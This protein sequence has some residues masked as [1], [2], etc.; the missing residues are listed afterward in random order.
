MAQNIIG[1]VIQKRYRV[2][3]F[4]ASGAMKTVYRVRDLER[5]VPLALKMLHGDLEE[6]P[7]MLRSFKRET[8]AIQE[9]GH[10]NIVRFYGLEQAKKMVFM[11]EEYIDGPAL[12]DILKERKKLSVEESLVYLK[13]MC[14]ALGYAHNRGIVH[15]DVKPGNVMVNQGGEIKLTDFGIARHTG[16]DTTS[17]LAGAGTP[18]Y[19]APE[20]V[21]EKEVTAATDVYALG[22]ML[23]EML[24]GQR[25]FRGT[26]S[27]SE[28]GGNTQN[29]RIRYAHLK[30]DPPDP[31]RLNKALSEELAGAVLKALEKEPRER[32]QTTAE[33][34]ET[35]CQVA[36]I[37][38]ARVSD[39]A[40]LKHTISCEDEEQEEDDRTP[41][42]DGGGFE[43]EFI[44]AWRRIWGRI[45]PQ[46]SPYLAL[47]VVVM[48]MVS[49]FIFR[50]DPGEEKSTTIAQNQPSRSII[51]PTTSP[52]TSDAET[53]TV[54]SPSP[55]RTQQVFTATSVPPTA[56]V[57]AP[58]AISDVKL[59]DAGIFWMGA[60]DEDIRIVTDLGSDFF[61]LFQNELPYHEVYLDAFYIDTYE[62][63]NRK[64]QEFISSTN[65]VTLAERDRSLPRIYLYTPSG[66]DPDFTIDGTANWKNPDARGTGIQKILD[67]PVVFIAWQDANAYCH[68][69]APNGHLPTEAQWVKAAR[70]T[71]GR[72]YP[73]GNIY[74]G[75]FLNGS[76]YTLQ[77]DRSLFM[78]D[79]GFKFTAP[80]GSY[81]QGASPYGVQDMLGNV[82]EWVQ[83]YYDG[84]YYASSPTN[85][86]TGPSI[87]SGDQYFIHGG[88]WYSGPKFN[89][90][91]R[92]QFPEDMGIQQNFG[93][94]CA[95]G[96]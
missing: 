84:N 86:P 17:T 65:Y 8:K 56:T 73:W 88:S 69:V 93:F 62:V 50:P 9:L 19:M 46:N 96:P 48:G 2:E 51:L 79:D 4:I 18:A 74:N 64:F 80:V 37:P 36:G 72:V 87:G 27:G 78:Y 16:S 44:P 76:D 25:P 81:P 11:L 7:A 82:S 58:P 31:R 91:S 34:F 5:S 43:P 40:P 20:Q 10:P 12:K 55:T 21:M 26:E 52:A 57:L 6:D 54:P 59:I 67:H 53:Q 32:Y 24:T 90:I 29:E 15:C 75:E 66:S 3:G 13:A 68:W 35:V 60:S 33:F 41:E 71:D 92:R 45:W 47:G 22:V 70:G 38:S 83:D 42:G 95:Y 77:Q 85:N 28:R 23:Y 89:R 49:F 39:R 94:R 30:L 1:Q 14:A 61:R 63:T